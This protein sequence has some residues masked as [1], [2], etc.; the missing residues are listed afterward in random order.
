MRP[1]SESDLITTHNEW[2]ERQDNSLVSKRSAV[3]R[4]ISGTTLHEFVR[5]Q[6]IT[7]RKERRRF[8]PVDPEK[9]LLRV[10]DHFYNFSEVKKDEDRIASADTGFQNRKTHHYSQ[11]YL[12]LMVSVVWVCNWDIHSYRRIKPTIEGGVPHIH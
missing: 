7:Y 6:K 8:N 9:E 4:S 10:H 11:F 3:C 1:K 2:C 12:G 5:K